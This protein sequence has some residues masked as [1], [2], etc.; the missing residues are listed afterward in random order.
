MGQ[1]QLGPS[2]QGGPPPAPPPRPSSTRKG[3]PEQDCGC[4]GALRETG[5]GSAW[6]DAAVPGPGGPAHSSASFHLPYPQAQSVFEEYRALRLSQKT[7]WRL[8]GLAEERMRVKSEA[9]EANQTCL[10]AV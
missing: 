6:K 4:R 8:Q 1:A 10:L 2:S 3:Q 7:V 9:P 5:T